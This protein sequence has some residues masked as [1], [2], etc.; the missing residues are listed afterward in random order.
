MS[1]QSLNS[2]VMGRILL[3]WR[4]AA[5]TSSTE[6]AEL[7]LKLSS[8][9]QHKS[10]QQDG[11]NKIAGASLFY[12]H[13]ILFAGTKN[14]LRPQMFKLLHD[15]EASPALEAWHGASLDA[16]INIVKG[17]GFCMGQTNKCETI[18]KWG[19]PCAVACSVDEL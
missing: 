9:M 17:P 1:Q 3:T 18:R 2:T 11:R 7:S 10:I 15:Q 14:P 16:I 8:N 6:F 4:S 19:V 13:Q 5:T 12:I